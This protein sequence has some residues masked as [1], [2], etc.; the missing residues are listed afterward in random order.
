MRIDN[1]TVENFRGIH[2]QTITLLPNINLFVGINGSGKST[3]LDAIALSLSWLVEGI[4]KIESKGESIPFESIKNGQ[5]YASIGLTVLENNRRYQWENVEF[6]RGYPADKSSNLLEL[7][8]LVYETQKGYKNEHQLPVIA[9]YPTNRIAQGLSQS[10][11]ATKSFSQIDVYENALGSYAN[12]ETFFEWFR[13]QDDIVN[14]HLKKSSN[15]NDNYATDAGAT[16]QFQM[17]ARA[18]EG[19]IPAYRNLRITRIPTPQMLIDKNGETLSLNQLS[20]GEK[21]MIAMI[22]DI[23]RRLAMANPTLPN[24]LEGDGVILI[25]ELDLHLH[26]AWQRMIV[27]KLTEV[28]PNC[29]FIV[30]THSPQILSHVKADHIFLLKQEN[31]TISVLKPLESYGKSSDRQLEDILGVASR[32]LAI[33]EE[34]HRL[35]LLIQEGN[36]DQAKALMSK[37]EDEIEGREPELVK[38][39]VLIQ[40]KEILGK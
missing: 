20:D 21:N 33:K 22:G 38:A 32:P 26:P 8:Q 2:K 9:Y 34:L 31:D 14:E 24:P 40:R 36:L 19:F 18:L 10:F 25:D 39:N 15:G 16:Q 28:F 3:V 13:L 23:A 4:Q 1:I 12:F 29:Q 6:Q 27:S 5:D 11:L 35:F 17:I 7:N 37:L 30:T